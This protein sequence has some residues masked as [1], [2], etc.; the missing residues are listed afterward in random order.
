M[1]DQQ[2]AQNTQSQQ[3]ELERLKL[4]LEYKKF[5]LG[6]VVAGITI[7]AI[8]PLF[9]L[10]GAAIEYV[11]SQ[12]ELSMQQESGHE[13]F[14]TQ[15]LNTALDQDIE[16]RIRFADY[17]SRVSS[18]SYR[19]GWIDYRDDLLKRRSGVRDEIDSKEAAWEKNSGQA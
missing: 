1:T 11:K 18:L 5:V 3:L 19:Q 9:Q 7:A 4:R 10:A 6:T 8:P 15:F 13:T 16:R 14:V 17:F 2:P 12:H